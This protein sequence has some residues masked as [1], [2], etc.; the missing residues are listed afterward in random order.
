MNNKKLNT[1]PLWMILVGIML[2]S[3]CKKDETV[4]KPEITQF[5]LGLENSETGY[6]GADLHIEAEIVAAGTISSIFVEIHPE[7]EEKSTHQLLFAWELDTTYTTFDG[8]K[9][10]LFHEH[11]TIPAEAD[12]GMYHFHFVV[13]DKQGYQTTIERDLHVTLPNDTEAPVISV[14]DFPAA[15]SIFTAG[16]TISITALLTDNL[17]L[18]GTYVGLVRADQGLADEEMNYQNTITLLHTHD[19]TDTDE[20]ALHAEIV[21]GAAMDNNDPPKEITGDLAW[22]SGEYYLLIKA[23]DKYGGHAAFSQRYYFAIEY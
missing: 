14:S 10:T 2:L 23:V 22:Q 13:T 1:Y 17:G 9:N 12:T 20:Y 3:S 21:V 18:G 8:L 15:T 5:E 11:V 6:V 7:R 4:S 19:F 16:Q